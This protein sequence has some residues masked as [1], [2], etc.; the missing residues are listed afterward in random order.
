MPAV[1]RSIAAPK[2]SGMTRVVMP[3]E[4]K[5]STSDRTTRMRSAKSSCGQR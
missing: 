1:I 4:I 2:A 3:I 5:T